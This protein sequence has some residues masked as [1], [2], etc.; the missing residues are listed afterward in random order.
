MKIRLKLCRGKYSHRISFRIGA[1]AI[2]SQHDSR[3]FHIGLWT[4]SFDSHWWYEIYSKQLQLIMFT[5]NCRHSC[6]L[7]IMHPIQTYPLSHPIGQFFYLTLTNCTRRACQLLSLHQTKCIWVRCCCCFWAI[8]EIGKLLTTAKT[9]TI[10][11]VNLRYLGLVSF[12]PTIRN[13][14]TITN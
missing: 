1:L 10:I 12:V 8:I 13:N 4:E 14:C 6:T 3:F 9:I 5:R 7:T 11:L 2:Y